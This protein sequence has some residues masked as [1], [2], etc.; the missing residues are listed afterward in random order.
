MIFLTGFMGS[1]KTTVGKDL[2]HLLSM[3]FVDLDEIISNSCGTSIPEIFR[4]AGQKAFRSLE[5]EA[6]LELSGGLEQYVVATGGGLPVDPDNRTVMKTCGS[7]IYLRTSFAALKKRIPEDVNRP[8]WNE[9]ASDL[10]DKRRE[11]YEDADIVIDT[12]DKTPDEIAREI[13]ST[14]KGHLNPVPVLLPGRSYPVYIGEGIF[15]GFNSLLKRHGNPEGIF[16]L[17]DENVFALHRNLVYEA[18]TENTYHIMEVPSGEESKS[19][20]FLKKILDEM[21][22]H[23]VNRSW[24]CLGIGGGV[25]GDLA[26]FAAS[27]FMRGIPV[28]HIPTTLLSQVDSSIGG[29]TGINNAF[30]KNLLGTFHQPLFVLSDAGFLNTLEAV[31]IKNAMAEVIKYGIIMD[32][33]LFEYIENNSTYDYKKI[34]TMCSR[35]KAHVVSNDEREGGLRRILNFGHTLG[36]ALEQ[37]S[38]YNLYHGQA[39]AVGMLFASWLSGKLG[40]LD[41]GDLRRIRNVIINENIIPEGTRLPGPEALTDT[42]LMDKKAS[43][44]G[45]H[46]VLTPSVGDVTV[47]K[48]TDSEVLDAYKEFLDGF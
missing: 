8:L 1:G 40:L 25:T 4:C 3:P 9:N 45:I 36:H 5:R 42:I 28:V 37:S 18:L 47:K 34:L 39:V 43:K 41:K 30:G 2:S 10:F 32:S 13:C 29:K 12:D 16:V 48:L 11:A 35:D 27:I 38:N 15:E 6:L 23:Q 20:G 17:I 14:I 7:I 22:S 26:G 19:Y 44:E 46:F 33:E 24:I 21:F 31:Q